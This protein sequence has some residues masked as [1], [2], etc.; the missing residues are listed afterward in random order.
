LCELAL[1]AGMA[2][3]RDVIS[4]DLVD[5]VAEELAASSD[6]EEFVMPRHEYV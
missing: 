4:E 5:S 3:E 2:E 1:I 6:G